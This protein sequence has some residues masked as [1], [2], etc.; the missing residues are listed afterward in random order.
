MNSSRR[1]SAMP[2][3]ASLASR[4]LPQCPCRPCSPTACMARCGTSSSTPS[5]FAD[6]D[7]AEGIGYTFTVGRNGGA[8]DSVLAREMPGDRGR[9]GCRRHRA[10]LGEGLVGHA[11]RRPRRPH[12]PGAVGLRHGAVGPQ[13]E[14]RRPAALEAPRRL[15]PPRALLRRRHRPRP[16]ARRAAARRPT[17]TSPRASAP[18][19]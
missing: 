17:T 16:A 2:A 12:R 1:A 13:G 3:I 15:R 6:A 18:S 19:R 5:A 9:R 7:G 11:L 10:A 14:A 4:P 8:I